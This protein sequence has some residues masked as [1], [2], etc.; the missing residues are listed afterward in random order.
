MWAGDPWVQRWLRLYNRATNPPGSMT[1]KYPLG[2]APLEN[3]LYGVNVLF[4]VR[5][6]CTTQFSRVFHPNS[7]AGIVIRNT[8]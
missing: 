7:P 4:Q 1:A 3:C 8:T 6:T 2:V 5:R